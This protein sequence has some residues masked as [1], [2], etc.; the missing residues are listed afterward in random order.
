MSRFPYTDDVHLVCLE[1][2]RAQG[3]HVVAEASFG[4]AEDERT[5]SIPPASIGAAAERLVT[6]DVDLLLIVCSSL[7][8]MDIGFLDRLEQRVRRPVLTSSQARIWYALRLAGVQAS[9]VGYGSL[10]TH[11]L[12][13]ETRS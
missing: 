13:K 8:T 9:I 2:V 3:L 10:F 5:A 6:P 4:I 7:R 1:W 12:R 11:P